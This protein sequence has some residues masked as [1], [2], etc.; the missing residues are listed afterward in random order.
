LINN[1]TKVHKINDTHKFINILINNLS[2]K[3]GND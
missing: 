2:V 1:D 3:K